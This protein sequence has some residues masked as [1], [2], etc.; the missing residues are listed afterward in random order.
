L[1]T[2]ANEAIRQLIKRIRLVPEGNTLNIEL[3]GELA[4]LIS[5]GIGSNDKHPLADTEGVQVTLVAGAGFEPA[6]LILVHPD[7]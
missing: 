7:F 3:F 5:L 4:A 1:I 2:Q 6:P